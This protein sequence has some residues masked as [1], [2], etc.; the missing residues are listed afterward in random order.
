[1]SEE[2]RADPA[3]VSV[4]TCY[5]HPDRETYIRCSRCDRP[6]CPDCMRPASV[7]FQCPECV[8]QGQ[9][10]Q[11]SVRTA[12]GGRPTAGATVTLTLIG[13]NV[14]A[15]V[16]ERLAGTDFFIRFAMLGLASN[17]T[18]LV[19]VA[20]GQYWRLVTA[21]FL[22][23]PYSWLH[24]AFNM[25]A[26]YVLGPPIEAMLGRARFLA[27]YLISAVGGTAASYAFLPSN[28]PSVGA[29][30]AIF[31]LFGAWIVLGRKRGLDIR[32]MWVLLAINLGLGFLVPGID[33]RGHIG[34][35]VAGALV[36]AAFAYAPRGPSRTLVQTA[37][38]VAVLVL[39]V[40][41]VAWRT[42]SLLSLV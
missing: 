5:R 18:E 25:Y 9:R 19:G 14:A 36:S 33:W 30:T 2:Q 38:A 1:M 20:E 28:V 39:V 32:P 10:T 35:L 37:G 6:I 4:P 26:L 29:S 41:L 17:G 21:A 40:G 7:G 34:G 12:F 15:Y 42:T 16:V 27:L 3:P 22:H 13:I 23:D 8:A 11:R 24:I 31:G